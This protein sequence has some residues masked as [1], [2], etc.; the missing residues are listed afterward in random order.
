[1]EQTRL[2]SMYPDPCAIKVENIAEGGEWVFYYLSWDALIEPRRRIVSR[3]NII[4]LFSGLV[5]EFQCI[6]CYH[7]I[8]LSRCYR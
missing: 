6:A 2:Q 5:G 8:Y 3:Q 4:S 7:V 1:M